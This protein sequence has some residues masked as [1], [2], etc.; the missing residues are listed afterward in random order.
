MWS[1][2]AVED[3]ESIADYIARDSEGYASA[4]VTKIVE[5]ARSV[6]DFP[7][8]GRM[9]PEF[10]QKEIRERF[11]YSYRVIYKIKEQEILIVAVIHGNRL[12]EN[13]SKR[14]ES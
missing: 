2:E 1:P 4:V 8:I 6:K 12:L 14:V 5:V 11:I 13:I 9:V 3:I 7:F 10:E